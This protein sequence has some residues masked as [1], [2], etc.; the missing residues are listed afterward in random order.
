MKVSIGIP[1]YNPGNF[2]KQSI[3]SIL[4]QTFTD[5]EL[6][7]LDDGS[8]DNSLEIAK[9]FDDRRIKVISD[10][11]NKSLPVR[12][13]QIIDI[14]QGEYIARM[15]ADDLVSLDR[16]I[17]QVKL[18]DNSPDIDIVATGLCSITDENEVIG[19]RQ[20]SVEVLDNLS[21]SDAI[22][23]LSGIAHA[24][25][26][27][28]KSWYLRNSYN[29]NT[30]LKEDYQLW[31]DAAIKKDLKV[32]FIKEP[33]YYYREESSVSPKKAIRAYFNGLKI[34]L[35]QY[36]QFLTFGNKVKIV[37]KTI[38]KVLFVFFANIFKLENKLLT[39][40]NKSTHQDPV[41]I[42]QLQ[43]EINTLIIN[44]DHK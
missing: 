34:V 32:A 6:I 13:N 41:L 25:I 23:G 39:L 19:Y 30:K 38:A 43:S 44:C 31:I 36:L 1:F 10:G 35:F 24:T 16:I 4:N 20:P 5:F 11:K 28:R 29:E 12:L 7:L 17:K 2:L 40:R 42:K 14:A 26:L 22:F 37:G 33:L 3:Y 18:L 8:T 21:V 9:S 15:D 27:V